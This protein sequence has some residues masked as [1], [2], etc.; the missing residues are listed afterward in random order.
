MW[1]RINVREKQAAKARAA[2][3][4]FVHWQ[5]CTC[6]SVTDV[7]LISK[8]WSYACWKQPNWS[9]TRRISV[10][11]NWPDF[12]VNVTNSY[13]LLVQDFGPCMAAKCIQ[14]HEQVVNGNLGQHNHEC[15]R[16]QLRELIALR[17]AQEKDVTLQVLEPCKWSWCFEPRH[18]R[19]PSPSAV[20]A[21]EMETCFALGVGRSSMMLRED[22]VMLTSFCGIQRNKMIL[23]TVQ[24][25]AWTIE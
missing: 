19:H 6:W 7:R 8:R 18:M 4:R 3:D 1:V 25:K 12:A 21:S 20:L 15:V 23:C 2:S 9:S 16:K 5:S 13:C 24:Q 14:S 11:S 22:V 17:L 10:G